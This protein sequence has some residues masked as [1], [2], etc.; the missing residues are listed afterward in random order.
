MTQNE[1]IWIEVSKGRKRLS[2]GVL[3]ISSSKLRN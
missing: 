3:L 1:Q 2:E